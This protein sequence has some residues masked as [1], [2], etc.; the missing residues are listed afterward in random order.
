VVRQT[1]IRP[2]GL[3]AADRRREPGGLPLA[4]GAFEFTGYEILRRT[5]QG[6]TREATALADL[7]ERD[8]RRDLEPLAGELDAMVMPR[9]RLAGLDLSRPR[10]M[11]VVNVTPDSFS[12]GG[13][14]DDPSRATEHALRLVAEGADLLDIGGESTRPGSEAVALEVELARVIP[15]IEG[16][17]RKSDTLISIDT[18]KAAVM[19]A[20]ATA[21]ADIL[22]DVSALT[23]DPDALGTAAELGLPVILMHAQGE[24][25]TMQANPRYADVVLDVFD[26]LSE[27]IAACEAAGIER[28]LLMADPGIGFG[29]TMSHNL[30]VMASL[31]LFHALGVPVLVGAS[32]K[33]FI[34]EISG[35]VKAEDRAAGSVGAALAA[36]A[37]GVQVLRVHDVAAT[38]A[39]LD[40]W[41][42]ATTGQWSPRVRSF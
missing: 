4:G 31:T 34:G 12:D 17:R 7:M 22:N 30:E 27:R 36:A 15:V 3:V 13:R 19:R 35:V 24:P 11:G 10:I 8:W 29:K 38:R 6:V 39:A 2:V 16:I 18:R 25:K 23:H 33:R 32:R 37:A 42:A 9:P 26:H 41:L 1:Y 40:V 28:R 21:G 5:A 20:A 14:Y